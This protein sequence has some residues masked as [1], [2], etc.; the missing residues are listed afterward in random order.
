[1]ARQRW[2]GRFAGV[3]AAVVVLL[4]AADGIDSV[5]GALPSV[6]TALQLPPYDATGAAPYVRSDPVGVPG[7]LW[8]TWRQP[9]RLPG[10]G[11]VF[12]VAIPP[13]LSGF[14]ARPA[15]V[16][17]PPAGLTRNPPALPLLVMIG[18]QPG[19]PRDWL[20]G[21]RLAQVMDAWAATHRGIAPIVVMPDGTGG[22]TANP[23]CMD[24]AL[25]RADTYLAQD[26][27]AWATRTLPVTPD[28]THWAVGGFSYGGT[29]A[30]QLAVA[31]PALFPT[32]FDT[33]GQESPTLG[34][35]ART[36]AATFGGDAAAFAAVDP[37]TQL[38]RRMYPGSAAFLVVGAQ[39]STYRP[40]QDRVAAA[41]RA[42][43]MDV[44][45]TDVP[46]EH[47][48]SVWRPALVLALPW[49]AVRMGLAP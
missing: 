28:R 5:Y 49:L 48:W 2:R 42:A 1:M 43:G 38:G 4:G 17:L 22:E 3:A 37:L 8:Q 18:G 23:L 47:S 32:F 35:R 36:V 41:A 44:Q 26:V 13:T 19:G 45:T 11:E 29:C 15:W 9:A 27:P 21:G 46:G 7:P 16:Y 33:S 34:S 30:L 20:D 10:H 31:H 14:P 25:G 39:D 24:F 40:Q 6:A 12:Q